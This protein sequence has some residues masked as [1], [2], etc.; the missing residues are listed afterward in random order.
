[1]ST[2]AEMLEAKK[3]APRRPSQPCALK[4]IDAIIS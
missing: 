2:D 3:R 4:T 1:M